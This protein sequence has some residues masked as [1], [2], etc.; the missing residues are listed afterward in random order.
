MQLRQEAIA[1]AQ[2]H[3]SLVLRNKQRDDGHAGN[4]WQEEATNLE[5][6]I[7]EY[8]KILAGPLT[9]EQLRED[10][11]R[12][13]DFVSSIWSGRPNLTGSHPFPVITL[14]TTTNLLATSANESEGA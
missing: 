7:L 9:V 3:L 11:I 5:Q 8:K 14:A 4:E 12:V 6:K 1:R 10:D 2:Y 13:L